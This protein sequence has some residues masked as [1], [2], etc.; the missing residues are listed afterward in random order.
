MQEA[1]YD[2]I[3]EG[4]DYILLRDLGPWDLYRTIT[5]DAENVVA[6]MLPYL[7]KRRLYYLDSHGETS[8][9]LVTDGKFGGFGSGE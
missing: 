1:N 8:E 9:L 6:K 5:S 4:P 2:Q 7:G 3:E